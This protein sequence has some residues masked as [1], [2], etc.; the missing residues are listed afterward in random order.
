MQNKICNNIIIA[1]S[2]YSLLN[3]TKLLVLHT[4]YFSFLY[5]HVP[6]LGCLFAIS[7]TTFN[8]FDDSSRVNNLQL[9]FITC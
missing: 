2:L 6:Q 1:H 7:V 8:W 3:F 4:K 9:D 5:L